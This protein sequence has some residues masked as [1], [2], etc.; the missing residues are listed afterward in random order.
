MDAEMIRKALLKLES[1]VLVKVH[2]FEKA[3]GTFVYE[4]KPFWKREPD[5]TKRITAR[6][7]VGASIETAESQVERR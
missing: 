6:V 3:T 4:I 7:N 2:E 5:D 1:E